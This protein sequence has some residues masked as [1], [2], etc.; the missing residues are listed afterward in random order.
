MTDLYQDRPLIGQVSNLEE[1]E[2]TIQWM[3]GSYSGRWR[4]WKGKRG[5]YTDVLPSNETAGGSGGC[6]EVYILNC[7]A[8]ET[9]NER[10]HTSCN[11]IERKEISNKTTLKMCDKCV[12]NHM[13]RT[14]DNP[15]TIRVIFKHFSQQFQSNF[16]RLEV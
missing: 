8:R 7:V 4:A 16:I 14:H 6:P 15:L 9:E 2:F 1:T 12:K 13:A 10:A 5:Q 3:V 11:P